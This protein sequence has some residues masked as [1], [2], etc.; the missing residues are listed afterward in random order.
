MKQDFIRENPAIIRALGVAMDRKVERIPVIQHT[1]SPAFE[2]RMNRLLRAQDKSYYRFVNTGAKRAVLAL[3]VVILLL[4]TM[5]FS[6][7]A[8]REPVVQFIAEIYE[9]FF[10]RDEPEWMY[11][12]ESTRYLQEGETAPTT[13]ARQ[14]SGRADKTAGYPGYT[15]GWL[16]FGELEMRTEYA[17]YTTDVQEIRVT[18]TNNSGRELLWWGDEGYGFD[19]QYWDGAG[20][21]RYQTGGWNAPPDPESFLEVLAPGQTQVTYVIDSFNL[22]A[23]GFYRLTVRARALGESS[24]ALW[25]LR[26]Q[27]VF[28]IS[29]STPR[30]TQEVAARLLP[31]QT[32]IIGEEPYYP[33]APIVRQTEPIVTEPLPPIEETPFSF[34]DVLQMQQGFGEVRDYVQR[35]PAQRYR[36]LVQENGVDIYFYRQ[37]TDKE[38]FLCLKTDGWV[39]GIEAG[40]GETGTMDVLAERFLVPYAQIEFLRFA[41]AGNAIQPPRGIQIG[42]PESKI[43]DCYPD[44]RR[45]GRENVLYDVTAIYPW[46]KPEQSITKYGSFIGGRKEAHGNWVFLTVGYNGE[47]EAAVPLEWVNPLRLEY[48][49]KDGKVAGITFSSSYD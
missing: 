43:L 14:G 1:F 33:P 9:I 35:M 42:D 23:E 2:G 45:A 11:E 16:S 22:P 36:Y 44:Y 19:L 13:T 31:I 39:D 49:I 20:W 15:W 29:S 21:H 7:S 10:P 24:E 12:L 25:D 3:A 34:R 47:D 30:L 4:I 41:G 18:I 40:V 8:L 5:V 17:L 28:E 6:V 27:A 32:K 48:F 26:M 46:A 37:K 38:A